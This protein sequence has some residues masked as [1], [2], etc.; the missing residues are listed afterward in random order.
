[1]SNE[2]ERDEKGKFIK[3]Q[4]GNPSGRQKGS[5]NHIVALRE[6][7]ELALRDYLGSPDNQRKAMD[8][9]DRVFDIA[10]N[11]SDK[12]A[13]G[14]IKL[15]MDKILPNARSGVEEDAGKQRPVAITIVNQ[16]ENTGAKP[17]TIIDGE[18]IE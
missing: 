17:M 13:V 3:G 12:Q 18:V 2:V 9:I 10:T 11:G 7:T 5:K 15:L 6:N 1:M 16:T 4:S 14:A 8:A